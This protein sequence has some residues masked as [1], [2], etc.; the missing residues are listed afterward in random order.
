MSLIEIGELTI[1]NVKQLKK[2]N[3]IVFPVS[4]NEKFYKEVLEVGPLAKLGFIQFESCA[5][6]FL[7]FTLFSLF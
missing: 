3:Q 5:F 1:H 2:I 4:Y 6:I 7:N